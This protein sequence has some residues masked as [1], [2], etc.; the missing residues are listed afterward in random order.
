ME[1]SLRTV[2]R[3][4][5]EASSADPDRVAAA[6]VDWAAL[7]WATATSIKALFRDPGRRQSTATW[8]RS[9]AW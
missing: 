7:D 3:L 1:S 6:S 2:A 4:M 5:A 8:R 9:V